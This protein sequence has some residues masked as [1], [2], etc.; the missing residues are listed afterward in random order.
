MHYIIYMDVLFVVNFIM[1]YLVLTVTTGILIHTT[2]LK[3]AGTKTQLILLYIKR[4]AGSTAGAAWA[5]LLVWNGC[6]VRIWNI[7][8]YV[9]MGPLMLAI[10]IG[11]ERILT[12]LKAVGVLYVVTFSISGVVHFVYY[13]TSVGYLLNGHNPLGMGILLAGG[14]LGSVLLEWMVCFLVK[15]KEKTASMYTVIAENEQGSVTL[16]ALC[17]T[18]N[19]LMDPFFGEPVSVVLSGKMTALLEG[20]ASYHLIPYSSI[21]NENGV[22]PVVRINR[23]KIIG[24]KETWIVEKPLLALY[25]GSFS[26]NTDYEFIIH[27]DILA[28]TKG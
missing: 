4:I 25:S 16:K 27:P 15:Q 13:Y 28:K 7:I 8:T 14:I 2:T 20:N 12:Y 21:G 17:D 3:R 9:I 24:G 19:N 26:G 22:I 1:D 6:N 5:C 11:K 23:L 10:V 18:G